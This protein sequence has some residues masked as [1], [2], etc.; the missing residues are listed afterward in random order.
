MKKTNNYLDNSPNMR[1]YLAQM[2]EKFTEVFKKI[3]DSRA[4]RSI[5]EEENHELQEILGE[6]SNKV[7]KTL[8][9]LKEDLLKIQGNRDDL[10]RKSTD[11][12]KEILSI[13]K[14]KA[15]K[16]EELKILKN[17]IETL[18]KEAKG[19]NYENFHKSEVEIALL[20]KKLQD[21]NTISSKLEEKRNSLQKHIEN[22]VSVKEENIKEFKALEDVF[23][24]YEKASMQ[25]TVQNNEAV[26]NY[27]QNLKE[28][29][30]KMEI[31]E[32]KEKLLD[33]LSEE[34]ESK[35]ERLKTIISNNKTMKNKLLKNEENMFIYQKLNSENEVLSQEVAELKAK[36]KVIEPNEN[37]KSFS[38]EKSDY[39]LMNNQAFNLQLKKNKE[40]KEKFEKLERKIQE[41]TEEA[42]EEKRK[43]GVRKEKF[44]DLKKECLNEEAKNKKLNETYEKL[45]GTLEN[46]RQ[47]I[48]NLL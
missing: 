5:L 37:S 21:L 16:Q 7:E 19:D 40:L 24:E 4:N 48:N 23:H 41:K 25:K 30:Q 11:A 45:N 31:V 1:I 10:L 3:K 35:L 27:R 2:C 33:E 34:L 6:E 15:E 38:I 22:L 32:K 42:T 28:N 36:I 43:E 44:E 18:K 26:N 39:N 9:K 29:R 20:K 12:Q 8:Q 14:L 46:M 17:E 13:S 47:K